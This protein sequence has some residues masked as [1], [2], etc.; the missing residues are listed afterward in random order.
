MTQPDPEQAL[1]VR[2]VLWLTLLLSQA[3]YVVVIVSG[4]AR[5]AEEPPDLPVLPIALAV[6]AVTTAFGAHLSWKRA[7]G[8]GRPA[9]SSP[10]DPASSL[11]FSL[12][13]WVL[14]ESI[15]VF[16]LTLGIMAFPPRV[17]GP[18]SLAAWAL[19]FI[20]RPSRPPLGR[21]G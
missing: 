11:N 8:A 20:H 14:D 12:V 3:V 7:A 21:L 16:G 6:V 17:W 4:V 13:A 18:F 15:G 9:H 2:R 1:R 19:M 10:P 5:T